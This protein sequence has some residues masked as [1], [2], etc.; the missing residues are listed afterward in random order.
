MCSNVDS[1]KAGRLSVGDRTE[2]LYWRIENGEGPKGLKPRGV[3]VLI[4]TNDLNDVDNV[5]PGLLF[6]GPFLIKSLL[7]TQHEF[8]MISCAL[9][10]C[11]KLLDSAE[12]RP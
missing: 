12:R 11:P 7:E 2:H 1:S 10:A 5:S 8:Y 4:G 3:V 6:S 9:K